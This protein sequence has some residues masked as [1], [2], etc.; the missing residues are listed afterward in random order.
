MNILQALHEE[1]DKI[2]ILPENNTLCFDNES[3]RYII[4]TTQL[5]RLIIYYTRNTLT[6]EINHRNSSEGEKERRYQFDLNNP[7]SI[8]NILN[9][10]KTH[11]P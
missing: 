6:I 10:I 9:L 2:G 7:N 3:C 4:V 8:P 1:I 11:H 5:H